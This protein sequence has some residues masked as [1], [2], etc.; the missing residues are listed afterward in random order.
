MSDTQSVRTGRPPTLQP[1]L[2]IYD[3][4]KSAL[5][6]AGL[7]QTSLSNVAAGQN[8][9]Y[10]PKTTLLSGM[11]VGMGLGNSSAQSINSSG[12]FYAQP[13]AGPGFQAPRFPQSGSTMSLNSTSSGYQQQPGQFYQHPQGLQPH[14]QQYQPHAQQ[15]PHQYQQY[16]QYQQQYQQQHQQYPQQHQQYQQYQHYAK[17]SLQPAQPINQHIRR[18]SQQRTSFPASPSLNRR[19]SVISAL[20]EQTSPSRVASSSHGANEGQYTPESLNDLEMSME[21]GAQLDRVFKSSTKEKEESATTLELQ[22]DLDETKAAEASLFKENELLKAQIAKLEEE[23]QNK[24]L[25]HNDET[26]LHSDNERLHHKVSSLEEQLVIASSRNEELAAKVK[27]EAKMTGQNQS[28]KLQVKS[29]E[30]HLDEATKLNEEFAKKIS[31]YQEKYSSALKTIEGQQKQHSAVLK[32]HDSLK[33]DYEQLEKVQQNSVADLLNLRVSHEKLQNEHVAISD[34]QKAIESTHEALA[35]EKAAHEDLQKEH[36]SLK[37]IHETTTQNYELQVKENQNLKTNLESLE[38]SLKTKNKEHEF[39]TKTLEST[40]NE[41]NTTRDKLEEMGVL[42]E[43]TRHQNRTLRTYV[44]GIMRHVQSKTKDESLFESIIDIESLGYEDSELRAEYS[45]IKKAL[46]TAK[47]EHGVNVYDQGELSSI[48]P[49]LL[50]V[51]REEVRRL[52]YQLQLVN[53]QKQELETQYKKQLALERK[54]LKLVSGA[55]NLAL[56]ES[57]VVRKHTTGLRTITVVPVLP[58]FQ[59]EMDTT[60]TIEP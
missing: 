11:G 43:D 2:D 26:S 39:K 6:S 16:Q 59:R 3:D 55:F 46:S 20:V 4:Q 29:M 19:S 33:R 13:V 51:F 54:T 53:S 42:L 30:S 28:L 60:K 44:A 32:S 40:L 56:K 1:S 14:Y 10:R 38:V 41:F 5:R 45:D 52:S 49:H 34:A 36:S 8:K 23:S 17:P 12:S 48:Q 22:R 50:Q 18:L 9:K 37:Q 15:D 21:L 58:N 25:A 7:K 24:T 35:K 47:E 57:N 27:L 31:E